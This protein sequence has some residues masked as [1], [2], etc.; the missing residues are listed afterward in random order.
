MAKTAPGCQQFFEKILN[1]FSGHTWAV[2][3]GI[4]QKCKSN[5]N[6]MIIR[7]SNYQIFRLSGGRFFKKRRKNGDLTADGRG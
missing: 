7:L 3:I 2:K 5:N 4:R 1:I 6:A